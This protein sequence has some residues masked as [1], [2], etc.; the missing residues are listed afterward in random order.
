MPFPK[1]QFDYTI[2]SHVIE[3][4][5]EKNV[6]RFVNEMQRVSV[7][8][9]LEAPSILLEALHNTP[10]HVWYVAC[11]SGILHLCQ[12]TYV[13]K[14]H[15]FLNLNP[16]FD[17]GDFRFVI[18]KHADLF[19]TGM[20]WQNSFEVRVHNDLEELVAMYPPNWALELVKKNLTLAEQAKER[21]KSKDRIKRYIPPV[22][23]DVRRYVLESFRTHLRSEEDNNPAIEWR[24]LVVCPV[25]H[26][27]LKIDLPGRYIQCTSCNR[28]YVI[29]EDGVPS[30]IV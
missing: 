2:A 5:P 4:I 27:E 14:W 29:R 9:Y 23:L 3:H 22:M 30:F 25:C 26:A 28:R 13:S 12:K 10:E 18:E 16:L 6:Q 20:E 19:F 7:R 24:E 15:P 8:G 1:A 17:D 21:A 11:E